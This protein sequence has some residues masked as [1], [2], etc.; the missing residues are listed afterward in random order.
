MSYFEEARKSAIQTDFEKLESVLNEAESDFNNDS[1]LFYSK[2]IFKMGK[3]IQLYSELMNHLEIHVKEDVEQE[4][5]VYDLK[6][7][8]ES[9]LSNWDSFL[10][11][12][13][14]QASL[15]Y[16]SDRLIKSGEEIFQDRN[17]FSRIEAETHQNLSILDLHQRFLDSKS[18]YLDNNR[19]SFVHLVMLRH[20]AW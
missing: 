17:I 8:H 7:R 11:R 13:E 19:P 20:F 2:N 15:K 14:R 18:E 16:Q 9:F 10:E 6:A 5:D 4:L 3:F 1:Q 12:I